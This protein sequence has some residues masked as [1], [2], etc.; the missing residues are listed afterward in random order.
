MYYWIYGRYNGKLVILGCKS[1][2]EEANQYGYEKLD[3]NFDVVGLPT[4]D[5]GRAT[6][7]IKARV[8][9][10]TANIDTALQRASHREPT[11]K[12]ATRPKK[13]WWQV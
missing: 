8:L 10:K 11:A 2:E 6:S 3:F 7:M 9:D 12:Q 5:R 4:K 1:S 13:K